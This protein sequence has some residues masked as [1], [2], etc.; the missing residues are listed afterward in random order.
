L[1]DRCDVAPQTTNH[2]FSMSLFWWLCLSLVLGGLAFRRE[3]R[4]AL[5]DLWLAFFGVRVR[6]S[7]P[8][9]PALPDRPRHCP[10]DFL[11]PPRVIT[12]AG[13]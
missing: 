13:P 2:E 6:V 5:G 11:P 9:V 4:A 7:R 1:N 3:V 10:H 12:R 8:R